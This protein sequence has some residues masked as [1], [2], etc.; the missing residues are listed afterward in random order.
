MLNSGTDATAIKVGIASCTDGQGGTVAKEYFNRIF[1]TH[2]GSLT[3][4]PEFEDQRDY[5]PITRCKI[6]LPFSGFHDISID[7][8]MGAT[9]SL[10]ANVDLI[11]GSGVYSLTVERDNMKAILYTWTFNC[12][13]DFPITGELHRSFVDSLLGLSKITTGLVAGSAAG[14]A[15]GMIAGGAAVMGAANLAKPIT[16][17]GGNIGAIDGFLTMTKPFLLIDIPGYGEPEAFEEIMG[18][19]A[20]TNV[21]LGA[22]KGYTQVREVHVDGIEGA[23]A[24]EK[25][26][27]GRLLKS[28]VIL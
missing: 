5:E 16:Y 21:V 12:R 8:I 26:E 28:G 23:T 18:R 1:S 22:I 9:I 25:D 13:A 27:I 3:I 14:G 6:F 24:W 20:N 10:D 15:V 17:N 19:S 2:F 11:S 4:Y 7:D